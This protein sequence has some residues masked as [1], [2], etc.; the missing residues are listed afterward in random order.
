VN[1]YIVTLAVSL[2][3]AG[4]QEEPSATEVEAKD[5]K[6]VAAQAS[7]SELA[8]KDK[9]AYA[10]GTNL[11]DSVSGISNEFKALSMDMDVVKQ[12]FSDRLN[13][14]S[15]LS[16]EEIATQF[17]IF[18]QK[19]QFAQQQKMQQASAA[20][21]AENEKFLKD[22]LA[23][24]FTQTESGLQYKVLEPA[25]EGAAKPSAT[26]KVKVHYTGTFIDGTKFDSSVDRG[27][28]FEFS[29]T[30]GV[31]QGWL[32]GVKLMEVGSKYQ[33]VI[34]SDIAYGPQTRGPIPGGSILKFD[35]E[36]LEIVKPENADTAEKAE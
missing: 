24:G 5:E 17:Q 14:S 35:I 27:Q 30:G 19:M 36:L 13:K 3:L 1:K 11:A 23:N 12:G 15:K 22:N 33:F 28:P 7:T 26:D 16:D 32:E 9:M 6:A 18:Q 8:E 25:K 21:T 20:K 29:L 10:I 34:P 4:C 31:I 2:A